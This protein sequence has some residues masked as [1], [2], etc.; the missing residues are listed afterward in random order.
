MKLLFACSLVL[1]GT[2]S[3]PSR[4][5]DRI[6]TRLRQML[7]IPDT[8]PGKVELDLKSVTL[9]AMLRS[10]S[11]RALLSKAISI[12]SEY[13][14]QQALT[15]AVLFTQAKQEWNRNQP[16]SLFGTNRF[17]QGSLEVGIEKRLSS[18]TR[19]GIGLTEFRN[20]SSF[21]SFGNIDTKLAGARVTLNQSLWRDFLGSTTRKWLES[22]RTKSESKRTQLEAEIED[23]FIQFSAL[24]HQVWLTQRRIE[25]TKE[26]L[27]RKERLAALF[28]RRKSLGISE[29]AEQ[30]QID[31]AVRQ[32]RVQLDE[33]IRLLEKQW[34][35]LVVSL[36][37]EEEDRKTDP[38][39]IPVA[40]AGD[41]DANHG[42]CEADVSRNREIRS[43][44]LEFHAL[45]LQ[46]SAAADQFRPD[47]SLD[48]GLGT[49]GSVLNAADDF[50]NRWAN[51]LS[52]RYP[53]YTI[54]LSLR[55]PLD[56]SREKSQ[57]LSLASASRQLEARI[58]DLKARLMSQLETSC[59]ELGML[60]QHHLLYRGMERDMQRRINLEE[61][62]YRQARTSPFSV[63]QAGDELFG[64]KL[65][66]HTS[67]TEWWN[68][69]WGLQ[70]MKGTLYRQLDLWV[71]EKTG[72]SLVE[73]ARAR[74]IP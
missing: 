6:Q 65:S 74:S 3:T 53:A 59:V 24:F 37:L 73:I 38:T 14:E 11:F 32:T 64:V 21:G 16:T 25:A 50:Q 49:N 31:S 70:K 44:E 67:L 26:S 17:D 66:L 2:I 12:D 35:L 30:I 69:H 45:E 48:L 62:R 33:L 60:R 27:E 13:L 39:Q 8:K 28:E 57:V 51:T 58:S 4:A 68:K 5:D 19:L 20:N 10:D 72:K 40:L 61:T 43:L 52:L 34:S 23:W 47:L 29:E 36:K 7:E 18:G 63:L 22:G 42:G 1:F 9:A 71:S 54:G 46:N 15:D 55:V 56:A 41:L